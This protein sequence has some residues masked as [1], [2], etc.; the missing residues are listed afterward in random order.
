MKNFTLFRF[1]LPALLTCFTHPLQA[2]KL[3]AGSLAVAGFNFDNPDEFCLLALD[4]LPADTTLFITD[5]GWD[6]NGF[7]DS[8]GIIAWSLPDTVIPAGHLLYF[9]LDGEG[10]LTAGTLS[11]D[12]RKPSLS[13]S[14]DQLLIYAGTAEAPGFLFAF[15]AEG[16]SW[17]SA[18]TTSNESALP[19]G[20]TE[21]QTALALPETDN[22]IYAGPRN[23][24]REALLQQ[25]CNP[26][27]WQCSN[28]QRQEMP[29][30]IF[31][32]HTWTDN[33]PPLLDTLSTDPSWH[34][35]F[36]DPQSSLP[37]L[38]LQPE[39]ERFAGYIRLRFTEPLLPAKG[40]A[41]LISAGETVLG[42]SLHFSNGTAFI[43]PAD[44]CL[45]LLAP[46]LPLAGN[47]SY[48][49]LIPEGF[50]TDTAGN[51]F[52]GFMPT[53]FTFSTREREHL[54]SSFFS[55]RTDSLFFDPEISDKEGW[56][57]EDA[58][59]NGYLRLAAPTQDSLRLVT[60]WITL[61][62]THHMHLSFYSLFHGMVSEM[63]VCY[64]S[65]RTQ[66]EGET[67]AWVKLDPSYFHFP[68][69]AG[70]WK[71]SGL[72]DI[73]YLPADSIQLA[74][75]V[76]PSGLSRS[77]WQIDN[78]GLTGT[79]IPD[80][81]LEEEQ[82]NCSLQLSG[83]SSNPEENDTVQLPFSLT[84]N[85]NHPSGLTT[86]AKY[87]FRL[88]SELEMKAGSF[89]ELWQEDSLI[90]REEL[91]AD[92]NSLLLDENLNA[93]LETLETG[94][95]KVI[96]NGLPQGSNCIKIFLHAGYTSGGM[97]QRTVML[98]SDSV[99]FNVNPLSIRSPEVYF[100]LYPNPATE[101]LYIRTPT[102][103]TGP[104]HVR[105]F[106]LG[107]REAWS[108]KIEFSGHTVTPIPLQPVKT[109]VY[110]LKLETKNQRYSW[111]VLLQ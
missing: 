75:V 49:L 58:D 78:I 57:W 85:S 11:F 50:V 40:K 73:D 62:K 46:S 97:P 10:S 96:T 98:A 80:G 89:M 27:N 66:K 25:I 31:T 105:L 42:D 18:A 77:F 2:Q 104:A 56:G 63:A 71:Y 39:D 43:P 74:F 99:Y 3:Q 61:R 93:A 76:Y 35:H 68:E 51:A 1:L 81:I 37:N 92:T 36:P 12:P 60:P 48:H 111:R 107:G 95:W 55:H 67:I 88:E 86:Y 90:H 47:T 6:N 100:T 23:G 106:D 5:N 64:R 82:E 52:A 26:E 21:G 14:G 79:P 28:S 15:N 24:S 83:I 34:P 45:L 38:M 101:T 9:N 84:F 108:R 103:F 65:N 70:V 29:E 94:S 30:G 16:D 19:A 87:Y 7:R 20:L 8:E 102:P 69:E 72:H 53:D 22:G 4:S 91:E 33:D 110:I 32:F 109:G 13:A 54:R 44:S 59:T 17:Q 41:A